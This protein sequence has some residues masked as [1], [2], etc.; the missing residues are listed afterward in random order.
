[1]V[2][3]L[4]GLGAVRALLLA[5]QVGVGLEGRLCGGAVRGQILSG[6]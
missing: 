5:V 3:L 1:M 4:L 6:T 2:L